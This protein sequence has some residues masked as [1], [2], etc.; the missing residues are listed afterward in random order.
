MKGSTRGKALS[1]LAAIV[2]TIILSVVANL[3]TPTVEQHLGLFSQ[4]LTSRWLPF[5]ILVV[6]G[7]GWYGYWWVLRPEH[8]T[9][10]DA[11]YRGQ[12]AAVRD[13]ELGPA[14]WAAE[15]IRRANA[16]KVVNDRLDAGNA[17]IR[18]IENLPR[19]RGENAPFG[20]AADYL[21]L[22]AKVDN[23]HEHTTSAVRRVA[24]EQVAY[25]TSDAGLPRM[26]DESEWR[27]EKLTFLSRR[28]TRLGEIIARV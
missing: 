6:L 20:Y 12:P 19:H 7:L 11:S 8:R 10:A 2:A 3:L 21:E 18:G 1:G 22:G 27:A 28:L 25:Y 13:R 26:R 4:L 23:W 16:M 24:P 9:S 5:G 17:L 15:Q 14:E